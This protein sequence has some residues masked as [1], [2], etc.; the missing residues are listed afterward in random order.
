MSEELA[1]L[2]RAVEDILREKQMR[3]LSAYNSPIQ[4]A[5]SSCS[6]GM[7]AATMYSG[8]SPPG[9]S[10]QPSYGRVSIPSIVGP[11]S[12]TTGQS[13]DR[14]TPATR[15]PMTRENSPE[16]VPTQAREDPASQPDEGSRSAK[17]SRRPFYDHAAS[18]YNA[19][20]STNPMGSLYEVTRLRSLR[21]NSTTNVHSHVHTNASLGS[22]SSETSAPGRF[23]NGPSALG[24]HMSLSVEDNQDDLISRGLVSLEEAEELFELYVSINSNYEYSHLSK[25]GSGVL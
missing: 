18:L 13:P 16:A 25:A 3:S 7:T 24:R 1:Q 14:P 20:L 23:S 17:P 11:A 10:S 4:S 15:M 22:D 19:S 5:A 9:S 8:N 21:S 6:P 12:S 2:Q